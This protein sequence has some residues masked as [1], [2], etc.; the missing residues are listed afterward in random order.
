MRR[1][2]GVTGRA[3]RWHHSL[4]QGPYLTLLLGVQAVFIFGVA[5][6]ASVGALSRNNVNLMH[7]LMGLL[8]VLV[9]PTRLARLLVLSTLSATVVLTTA[10]A[11]RP[12]GPG[13]H[14]SVLLAT[15]LFTAVVAATVGRAVLGGGPVTH[16][17]I[18]GAMVVYLHLAL[19]FVSLYGLLETGSPGSFTGM[20]A[21]PRLQ[22]G[23][24]LYFSLT[25]LTSTGYGDVLPLHPLARSLANL[26]SVVGQLFMATLFARLVSLHLLAPRPA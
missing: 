20:S 1:I 19:L 18:Q 14:L 7:L 12:A 9:V 24:L 15:F 16:H 26:E 6:L 10:E 22:F 2:R 13:L 11:L 3:V 4:L 21:N 17:R 25:T 5:P 8:S 23:Q